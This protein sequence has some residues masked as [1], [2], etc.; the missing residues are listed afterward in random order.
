MKKFDYE[1]PELTGADFGRFVQG[2]SVPGLAGNN[3]QGT[4]DLG[5]H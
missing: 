5:N 2:S 4:G 1:T 3:D